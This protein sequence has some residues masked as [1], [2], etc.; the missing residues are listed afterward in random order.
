MAVDAKAPFSGNAHTDAGF[1][2]GPA[3]DRGALFPVGLPLNDHDPVFE[4]Q[5]RTPAQVSKG[6]YGAEKDNSKD[7]G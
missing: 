5:Y 4:K 3:C 1:S 2:Q 6:P 7:D